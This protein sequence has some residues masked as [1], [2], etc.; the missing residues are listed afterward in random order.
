[1]TTYVMDRVGASE[2][3][4]KTDKWFVNVLG[5][6]FLLVYTQGYIE[7]IGG[8]GNVV[9]LII[10]VPVFVIMLHLINRGE[11]QPAPGFLL[12]ALYV[13]WS[14]ISGL[15]NGDGMYAAFLYCR[16]VL[17]AYL[18]FSAVWRTPLTR[19]AVMRLNT[20]VALL[21]IV[22]I[23]A[24]AHEVFVR[25]ERVEAHVGALYAAGGSLAT[26]FPLLAMGLTVPFYLYHRR[27]PLL[28]LL[29]W[30][31]FLVGYASG[32]RAIY[33]FAPPLYLLILGWY[34][35]RTRT[36]HA[37]KQ[38]LW[39]ASILTCLVPLLLL[40]MSRS[41]G[42]GQEHS[43]GPR[44]RVAQMFDKGAE[45]TEREGPTG[46]TEGRTAT[47]RRVL[48]MLLGGQWE[49][50][51][52]GLGPSSMREEEK[53]YLD[54]GIGYGICGWAQDVICI[55][56]PGMMLYVLFHVYLFRR[57]RLTASPQS[58][59]YW[60]ALR[61]GAEISLIVFACVYFS[62]SASLSTGGQLTYVYFYLLALLMSP[63]HRHIVQ[64]VS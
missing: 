16:Y 49:I 8:G 26:E 54:L 30:A 53:R 43:D 11:C 51:L 52:F 24:S 42:L 13:V 59:P 9:K 27:N 33:F 23:G 46:Q 62:Y 39:G 29:A 28:L 2:A 47:N 14:A 21:F 6:L 57:L 3:H 40:G 34:V 58:N 32:K 4:V 15:F 48:S 50:T 19:T 18:V 63:Q 60:L 37:L 5:V 45:Y 22:Q 31:F 61:F 55:G 1:M 56:W 41:H 64:S 20:I 25:G 36:L 44:E 35:V 38:S 17:Y 12:I 10:E 7:R